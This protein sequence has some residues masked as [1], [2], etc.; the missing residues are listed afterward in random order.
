M[1]FALTS[2]PV[3]SPDCPGRGRRSFIAH[4]CVTLATLTDSLPLAL[5]RNE[6]DRLAHWTDSFFSA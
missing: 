5:F 6:V 4:S 2:F 1:S 3:L